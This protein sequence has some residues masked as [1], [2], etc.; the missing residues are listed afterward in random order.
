MDPKTPGFVAAPDA[1][2]AIFNDLDVP[3]GI[4]NL[5]FLVN[6]PEIPIENLD[7]GMMAGFGS[8]VPSFILLPHTFMSFRL[9]W[10]C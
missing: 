5:Q 6:V 2:Y 8:P 1:F 10:Q 4:V 7:P 9:A 3:M